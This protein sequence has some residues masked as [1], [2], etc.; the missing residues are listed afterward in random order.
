MRAV[1][2]VLAGERGGGR[3][4]A[5]VAAHDDVDLHAAEGAVVEVVALEGARDEAR[6]GAEARRVV[7]A[8]QVV[9][10][11]LRDVVGDE[12]VALLLRLLGDDA[13]GVR[14]VVAADVEE[15][16]HLEALELL[17][18]IQL[19]ERL[20]D[21]AAVVRR[22]LEAAGPERGTRR[23]GDGAQLLLVDLAEVHVVAAEDAGD[24]VARAEDLADLRARGLRARREH[25]AHEGLVDDHRRTARLGDHH[26]REIGLLHG[27]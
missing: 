14:G 16:A 18:D 12:R 24:A 5:G 27:G 20:E 19:L 7:A 15:P 13:R 9:V 6:G 21:L 22:R 1:A 2:P 25:R 17:E 4:E 8:A 3:E 11:R 10:D 26:V 23:L